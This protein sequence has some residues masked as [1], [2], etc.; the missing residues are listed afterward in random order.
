MPDG[1]P[2]ITSGA[3]LC[4][5]GPRADD[6]LARPFLSRQITNFVQELPRMINEGRELLLRL[7]ELYPNIVTAPQLV[8]LLFSDVV[9][10]H[11]VAIIIAVLVFGGLWGFWGVF[12]AIPLTTLVEPL[13]NA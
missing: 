8:P 2:L 9:N 13:L 3:Q 6:I 11:R 4:C 5:G 7:P 1:V 10:L 12:F